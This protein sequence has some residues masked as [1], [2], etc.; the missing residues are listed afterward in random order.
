MKTPTKEQ[1]KTLSPQQLRALAF[2]IDE[3]LF[4]DDARQGEDYEASFKKDDKLFKDFIK[5]TVSA[6]ND[7][8]DYFLDQVRR[9]SQLV[10]L[11]SITADD[12]LDAYIM[13]ANWEYEN[14]TLSATLEIDIE[15]FFDI[16]LL[17]AASELKIDVDL[18]SKG[19]PQA[20][21]LRDYSIQLAGNINQTSINRIKQQI[22]TSIDLGEDRNKLVE[23]LTSVL[24]NEKR[25]VAIAQTESVR[26]YGEGRLAYGMALGWQGK[27]WRISPGA[28]P[29][30]VEFAK[31]GIVPINKSFKV[32]K[33][34][35]MTSPAHPNC[36]C[37]IKLHKSTSSESAV[38]VTPQ[39]D[40]FKVYEDFFQY[41]R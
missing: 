20:A 41:V 29:I 26:A 5:Q 6:K 33:I 25:A 40:P 13:A 36:R 9:L 39:V 18:S 30:C 14:Q 31:L 3:Y 22:Q 1:L 24:D 8:Y 21:F 17:A 34:E 11:Y 32:G 28:C 10:T 16:G 19:T 37:G 12:D 2:S 23:R 38:P 15:K 27:S 35:V 7:I 4:K